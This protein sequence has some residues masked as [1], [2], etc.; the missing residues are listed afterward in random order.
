MQVTKTIDL[1]KQYSFPEN[2]K[3][4]HRNESILIISRET[5]NW[6]VLQNEFQLDFFELLKKYKLKNAIGLFSGNSSDVQH[7][8]IQIEARRFDRRDIHRLDSRQKIH[9]YLTNEC[10]LR[11]PHCY[12]F[13]GN[14]GENELTFDEVHRVLEHFAS[15][16][17]KEITF[18]GGEVTTRKDF[19]D[20]VKDASNF[21]YA[22]KI[23]T[24][25]ILWSDE[26]IK[27]VAPFISNVQISIDGFSEAEDAKIRGAGHFRQ[28]LLTLDKFISL[29]V[30]STIAITPWYDDSF[31]SKMP[32]YVK[33]GRE[34]L[35]KYQG[36]KFEV[37]FSGELL[38]GRNVKLNQNQKET[39]S[40][41]IG[42]IYQNC[43]G[44]GSDE[45][46]ASSLYDGTVYN[47]CSFGGLV[48]SSTGDVYLCAQIPFLK[49]V[50]NIRKNTWE[51]IEKALEHGRCL[52][53][54]E[55]LKPCNSCELK[56]ICGGGCRLKFF[57]EFSNQDVLSLTPEMIVPRNCSEENKNYYYDMM[58][59]TNE[60]MF[61]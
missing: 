15:P 4:I 49:P 26:A 10:N 8:V 40:R 13:S 3:V 60:K 34:L 9:M 16:K 56:Y 57:E 27:S 41:Q 33:F 23:L 30:H 39:Y 36:E 1:E 47:N 58:I 6:I 5:A 43:F 28:A 55:N 14:K 2:L 48:L 46:F 25:G 18:S 11:C 38:D 24:N 21:G 51:E 29:G 31:E 17:K 35:N 12:M 53:E 37:I 20:I 32:E 45:I 54:I 19:L 61:K 50:A 44:Y 22:V 59:R 7:V 42:A 52:S